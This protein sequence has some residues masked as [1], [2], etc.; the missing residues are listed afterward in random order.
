MQAQQGIEDVEGS[1]DA[2]HYGPWSCKLVLCLLGGA[3]LHDIKVTCE[4]E[5]HF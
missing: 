3:W 4:R 1:L 2:I 5:V